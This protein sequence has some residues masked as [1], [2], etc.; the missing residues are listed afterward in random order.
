MSK[1]AGSRHLPAG[2]IV[3][4]GRGVMPHTTDD[5][6][7]THLEGC[8][9]CRAKVNRWKGF[10]GMVDRWAAGDPPS[11]AV[12]RVLALVPSRPRVSR[13]TRLSAVLQYQGT[14]IP[15][16]AGVRGVSLTDQVV[17]H[18]EDYAVELRVTRT[19][20]QRRVIL[21]GQVT[22]HR[23][24]YT[25]LGNVAV[26]L[27]TGNQIAVRTRSNAWGEFYI[28]HADVGPMWLELAPEPGRSIRIPVRP[29]T[30]DTSGAI[31]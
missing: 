22:S 8:G 7:R 29:R 13:L 3:D 14:G 2:V 30:A 6:V 25:R 28:E 24:P 19:R 16:P 15:L 20:S 10:S 26:D 27:V 21:V 18:A 4:A 5:A 23:Q 12:G 17:Y 11:A 9:R 31:P 1:R